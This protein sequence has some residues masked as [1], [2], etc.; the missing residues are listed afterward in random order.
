MVRRQASRLIA[1][2][3]GQPADGVT[4]KTDFLVCGYQDLYRL[5]AGETK[6][7]KLRHA[8]QLRAQGQE[9]EII[10]ERDFFRM[11]SATVLH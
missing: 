6:S 8:E 3:G 4:K 10:G 2:A 1:E 7:S 9:I 11:L 5:G